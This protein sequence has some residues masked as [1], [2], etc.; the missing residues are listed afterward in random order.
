MVTSALSKWLAR[1]TSASF[2]HL[3]SRNTNARSSRVRW[4]SLL[5]IFTP[6]TVG[7]SNN[8][9][10]HF[11]NQSFHLCMKT[12]LLMIVVSNLLMTFL[13]S[14][15]LPLYEQNTTFIKQNLCTLRRSHKRSEVKKLK[16]QKRYCSLLDILRNKSSGT[17]GR[18]TA[19]CPS[20][21]GLNP[22]TDLAWHSSLQNSCQS[23][24]VLF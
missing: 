8:C 2:S 16:C 7:V 12:H 9:S 3:S 18:A 20:G 17:S 13:G 21:L 24:L 19:F 10:L 1:S 15:V 14:I 23:I 22:G 5:K 6:R 4:K 11:S